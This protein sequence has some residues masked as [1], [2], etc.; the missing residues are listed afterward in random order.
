MGETVRW[1]TPEEQRAWRGFVRLH[2][3]LGGRL[4]RML[5]SE[6]NVS[7]ADFAVLVHLTDSPEGRR[8]YQDLARA[9]EWEKSRMSHHIARMAGRG[10]VVREEC[11]EDGR[12]AYVV[13]TD[14]GR[15]AIEAAAPR[16][17]EAVRELFM[18]HV[19]PAELRVLAEI[20]ERVIGKLDEDPT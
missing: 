19:T 8:R 9:L 12:G 13:I 18:D 16:H 1:L 11:A 5:Q 17:V 7:A 14:V 6:S 10:M 4:G 3:R 20:S 15:A 2:E